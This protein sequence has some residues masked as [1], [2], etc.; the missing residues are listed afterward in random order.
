[1]RISLKSSFGEDIVIPPHIIT[2]KQYWGRGE[3][4]PRGKPEGRIR[5]VHVV[6]DG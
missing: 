4:L 5:Y 6:L 2:A 1:M 3:Q